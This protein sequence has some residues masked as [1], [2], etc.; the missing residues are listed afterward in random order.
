MSAYEQFDFS[1][2]EALANE[3]KHGLHA[4]EK[5]AVNGATRFAKGAGWHG[6]F[7]ISNPEG[8]NK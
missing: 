1:F 2:E 7:A 6:D 4:I 3:F 8:E 5:E